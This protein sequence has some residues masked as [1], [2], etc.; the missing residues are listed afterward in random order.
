M[1]HAAARRGLRPQARPGGGPTTSVRYNG[2]LFMMLNPL[3]DTRAATVQAVAVLRTA[4]NTGK[5]PA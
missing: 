3:H 2:T 5:A 1:R 4:L